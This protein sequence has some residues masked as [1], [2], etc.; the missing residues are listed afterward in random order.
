MRKITII[1]IA[2]FIFLT[3]VLFGQD[4][5][6]ER[7]SI[8][9]SLQ[10]LVYTQSQLI[11]SLMQEQGAIKKLVKDLDLKQDLALDTAGKIIDWSGWF[12]TIFAV[13]FTIFTV[14]ITVAAFIAKKRFDQI[15]ELKKEF[16]TSLNEAR[17][18]FKDELKQINRLKTDFE[19]ES[20]INMELLFPLLEGQWFF[21]QGDYEK[22]IS[23]YQAAKKI[24]P[25]HPVIFNRLN[26][27]LVETGRMEEA[28]EDLKLAVKNA[29]EDIDLKRRLAQ[30]Y[31][32]NNEFGKAE[33]LLKE[34]LEK[35]NYAPAEYELGCIKLF[36]N[37][38]GKAEQYFEMANRGF[39]NFD[40]N[41]R[42]WATVNLAIAQQLQNKTAEAL[43]NAQEAQKVLQGF[44]SKIPNNP[45]VWIYLG[46]SYLIG[47]RK[48]YQK[49]IDAF[50]KAK[51]FGL[52]HALAESAKA[53]VDL[54]LTDIS[55]KSK[56][57]IMELLS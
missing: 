57:K 8:Q 2:S 12:F 30:S 33:I 54:L 53:R 32:R 39:M 47:K 45:Q 46:V 21:Y 3:P 36:S 43:N 48:A 34:I 27:L 37:Q 15:D 41:P 7:N 52:P 49:A 40:G 44:A 5:Q 1:I 13:L 9:D 28:I 20:K 10:E 17:S 29:P 38:L 19:E 6:L 11:D 16:E 55:N 24:K 22:A 26:K 50:Q 35:Q 51:E 23:S 42:Y 25:D 56:E 14:I 4:K 18:N 31:R